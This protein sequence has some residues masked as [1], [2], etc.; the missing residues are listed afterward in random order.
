MFHCSKSLSELFIKAVLTHL[1]HACNVWFAEH[2]IGNAEML[3]SKHVGI[4]RGSLKHFKSKGC[5]FRPY[6]MAFIS[7]SNLLSGHG[8]VDIYNFHFKLL[9]V[10]AFIIKYRA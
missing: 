3:L 7:T 6:H 1:D 9:T 5:N 8:S 2:N 4:V 10:G